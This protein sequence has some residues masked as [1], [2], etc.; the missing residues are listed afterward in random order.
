MI[1]GAM[2]ADDCEIRE[3]FGDSVYYEKFHRKLH[4]EGYHIQ[5]EDFMGFPYV[6][7]NPYYTWYERSVINYDNYYI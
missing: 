1:T 3:I 6:F 4:D 7:R 5:D 2:C